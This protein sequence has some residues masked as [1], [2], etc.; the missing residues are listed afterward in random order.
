MGC[1]SIKQKIL[2]F[3]AA[4]LY[5][6]PVQAIDTD[7]IQA[8]IRR[9]NCNKC[10]AVEKDGAPYKVIAER[11][12]G[13]VQAEAKLIKHI[14]SGVVV[15]FPDGHEEEHKIVRTVPANDEGQVKSL[16]QWLLTQ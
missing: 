16:V 10:H 1:R 5:C 8:L 11:Y 2:F 13:D 12:R 3:F 15:V 6:I 14:T 9:N 4:L 7:A